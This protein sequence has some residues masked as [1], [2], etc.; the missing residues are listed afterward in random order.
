MIQLFANSHELLLP[1]DFSFTLISE[2]S[3]ITNN[4]EFTLDIELSLLETINS[5]AFG[6]IERLNKVD[7][8]KSWDGKIIID[9]V[10]KLGK[11]V[12][13]DNTDTSIVIQFIAGNSELNYIA[14][15]EKKIWELDWGTETAID[16]TKAKLTLDQIGYPDLMAGNPNL[17]SNSKLI[18]FG[19]G[20]GLITEQVEPYYR[21]T[22]QSSN[23]FTMSGASYTYES[24]KQ[25]VNSIWIKLWINGPSQIKICNSLNESAS[26]KIYSV[27]SG[28]W[29]QIF[30]N[31]FSG[32][33]I[34]SIKLI[35]QNGTNGDYIGWDYKKAK[36]EVGVI[37]TPWV[38]SQAD[39]YNYVCT[40]VLLGDA[41]INDYTTTSH[42]GAPATITGISGKII[43]QPYL[44]YYVN[45]LPGL[46]GY[47]LKFNALNSDDRARKMYLINSVESLSY[48]DAL[49]DM[50]ISEFIEAIE[51]FFNVTFVVNA[52]DKSMS[53]HTFQTNIANKK[54]CILTNVLQSYERKLTDESKSVKLDFT[55]VSYD[56]SDNDYFKYQ[57]LNDDILAKCVVKEYANLNAL[58]I[59]VQINDSQVAVNEFVIYR[60]LEK[61]ND[62]F[63]FSDTI[64]PSKISLLHFPC[65]T[66]KIPKLV[67][68]FASVG[69]SN[70]RELT[71]KLTPSAILPKYKTLYY[72]DS[73][74]QYNAGSMKVFYQLPC[75]SMNY[76]LVETQSK[77]ID[78]IEKG[79]KTVPRLNKLEVA[80][81][82][83]LIAGYI[84]NKP[85]QP[86]TTGSH[87]PMTLMIYPFSH[88]DTLPEFRG[89]APASANGF[90]SDNIEFLDWVTNY[91]QF[92]ATETMRLK[93]LNGTVTTYQ[94]QNIVD[95]ELEYVFDIIDS[96]DIIPENLFFYD[97]QLYMPIAFERE[98]TKN[99]KLVHG[100]FYRVLD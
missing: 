53:I 81:Y 89:S 52:K 3:L 11:I 33:G 44:L 67:N 38:P 71:F 48:A 84:E 19:A 39:V 96:P 24:G 10:S 37:A 26:G 85:P 43:M 23:A 16:Y 18:S 29:Q 91:F 15:N 58:I 32:N 27:A 54:R 7:I 80:L 83:G 78:A 34:G 66:S 88:I 79:L 6:H 98:K 4:G 94:F 14:K 55:K 17:L 59:D 8:P 92:R 46:M 60:D 76:Y 97:N 35:M 2:N 1:D 21:S 86:V 22:L 50:G 70:L 65:Y 13:V 51:N 9:G 90:N 69:T 68:K 93:G 82:S 64:F 47:D 5:K 12:Y 87:V 31:S 62:Y 74:G 28:V 41:I 40:P 95:T 77:V 57:Q 72:I 36:I 45:K 30:T 75:G 63:I 42:D 49:P 99:Q 25:Y 73:G 20:A 56:L 61:S 100:R